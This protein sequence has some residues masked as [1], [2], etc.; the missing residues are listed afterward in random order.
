MAGRLERI[1]GMLR[2]RLG[3]QTLELCPELAYAVNRLVLQFGRAADSPAA[4][5]DKLDSLVFNTVFSATGGTMLISTDGGG[6]ARLSG[7]QIRDLADRLLALAYED[8]G[9]SEALRDALFDLSREGSFAAMRALCARFSLDGE[10][11][12]FLTQV[13]IEN[14]QLE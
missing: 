1:E 10:D 13:L 5:L 7:A 9:E 14:N 11:R 6:A 8:K 4:L 2:A 3:K 12:A